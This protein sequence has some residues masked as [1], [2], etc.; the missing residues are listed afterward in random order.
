MTERVDL[1]RK[2]IYL[3]GELNRRL[4]E[5]AR[6]TG[7][8][9]SAV[10]REALADYLAREERRH[11]KPEENPVLQMA[12]MFDGDAGCRDVSGDVDAYLNEAAKA[13][14]ARTP[15]KGPRI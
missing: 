15:A 11:T 14:A 3:T 2:Q 7:E 6:R 1:H 5:S 9:E 13:H 8:T 4:R 10:V 12:G